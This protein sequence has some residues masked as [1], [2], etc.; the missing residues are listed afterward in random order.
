VWSSS[1]KRMELRVDS[2][3]AGMCLIVPRGGIGLVIIPSR[4][5]MTQ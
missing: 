3:M 2:G 5:R 1:R 4:E